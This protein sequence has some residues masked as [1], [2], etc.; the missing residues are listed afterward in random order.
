ML[1]KRQEEAL[2]KHASHHS[3]KHMA[4][5]RRRMREG[6]SFSQAHKEAQAKVGK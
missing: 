1:T 5:M 4:F 6:A 2:K 3:T